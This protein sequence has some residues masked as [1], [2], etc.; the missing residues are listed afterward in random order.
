M[1]NE[2][3]YMKIDDQ[4]YDNYSTVSFDSETFQ[5]ET[6]ESNILLELKYDQESAS[7]EFYYTKLT[8]TNVTSTTIDKG[9]ITNK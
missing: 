9:L 6:N 1:N 5:K 4:E 3:Q 7:K 8:N 2:D